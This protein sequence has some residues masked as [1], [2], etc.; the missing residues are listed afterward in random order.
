MK[1]V[2]AI[3]QGTTSSRTILFDEHLVEVARAQKEFEQIFPQP[4]WVE[5]DAEVIWETQLET[6]REVLETAHVSLDDIAGIGITNQRETVVV[7]D[8][9]TGKPVYNAIVWQDRRTAG[10]C[11]DLKAS[12]LENYIRDNTGLVIDAYFSGTKIKWILDTIPNARQL[13]AENKLLCGTI[14]CWLIWKLTNGNVHAT[15][16]S[17]ASR[18]MLF[19]IKSIQWDTHL[20]QTLNIPSNILPEV[21]NSVDRFGFANIGGK[22]IPILGVAGDQQAALFGQ[23][24]FEP[25]SAKNT[26][27]TGCFM[28]MQTGNKMVISQQKLLTTIAWGINGNISYALEGSVFIGGAVVQW[29]RDSLQ[30]ISSSDE[31]EYIAAS[32]HDNGDV[33]FVP[34]F[35]GLGA[36]HWD[37]YAKGTISGLTRGTGRAHIIRAALESIAYQTRD[38]LQ[39]MNKDAG[40]IL[41]T[42]QVDGG[43][44]ANNWLMQFQS[45]ILQTQVVRP[46]YLEST[47]LGAASLA[48]IGAGLFSME[49]LSTQ[50][51]T[52]TRFKPKMKLVEADE[53]YFKWHTAVDRAKG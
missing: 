36:P 4:G 51:L 49:D 27:G 18:T 46:E 14:D 24:C 17:N 52:S 32:L 29:L 2:I 35:T 44:T 19:N 50:P 39:A 20:L 6:L 26:Y 45:D 7:W 34:A 15:D 23:R 33:Y 53:L 47:A 40:I 21:K 22:E 30:I 41:K 38:V 11:E 13:A 5:H 16:V 43:A 12:K 28:L 25:G 42:L 31:S 48:G 3:D 1:Y 8:K 10:I 9:T 37:M